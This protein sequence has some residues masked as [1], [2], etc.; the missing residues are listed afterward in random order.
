MALA[1]RDR[2]LE[3]GVECK[4]LNG[5]A[6]AKSHPLIWEQLS[7]AVY[8]DGSTRKLA[9]LTIF[10]DVDCVKVCLNDRDQFL[11]A[12]AAGSNVSEALS[13]LE[14]GLEEDTLDWRKSQFSGKRGKK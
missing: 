7:V 5:G 11:A 1:K 12:F 14:K 6:F 8:P 3:A 9:S 10:L 13:S 2:S 4:A